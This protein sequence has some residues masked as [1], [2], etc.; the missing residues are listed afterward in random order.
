VPRRAAVTRDVA[1]YM[2]PAA[3]IYE[4][5]VQRSGGAERQTY[6]LALALSEAG[7]D[8]A[9]IVFPVSNPVPSPNSRLTILQR[10]AKAEPMHGETRLIWKAL[11][12]AEAQT[13]VTRTATAALGI[14]ALF[15]RRHGRRLIFASANDGDFT[16]ET[17]GP[18]RRPPYKL[19]VH[20]ADA[21]VVQ[22]A[23]QVKLAREAFP[24]VKRVVEIPSF[25]QP[26][27]SSVI[28]EPHAFLWIGRL[29]EYKQPM[30]YIELAAAVPEA[31]FRMIHV[32]QD[33]TPGIVDTIR[34]RAAELPNFELLDPC[35]H[36]ATVEI[37]R[38]SVAVVSS[39][40]LEGMPNVFLEAW[41]VGVPVI[42]LQCDPDGRIA[43]YGLG[44]VANGSWEE[45]VAA[46]R[47]MW[48]TRADRSTYR[49]AAT[50]YLTTVHGR[51]QVA[52]QW[53][54]VIRSRS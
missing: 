25:V 12:E 22:S 19:G 11:L 34:R 53:M 43:K 5:G 51:D 42:S 47:N 8:V 2:P 18:R 13:Y 30:R 3:G 26:A 16:F 45:F 50:K 9:H 10:P 41:A 23:Q 4:R 33:A 21:V 44:T 20:L 49:A 52:S 54:Q 39:S 27:D 38:E 31:R 24:T 28:R 35:P 37:V 14:A 15:C 48:E 17:I 1:I 36:D 46:T 40:R 29:A 6:L 7:L 32:T